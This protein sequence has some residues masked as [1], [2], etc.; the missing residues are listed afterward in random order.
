MTER[1]LIKLVLVQHEKGFRPYLFEAPAIASIGVGDR[2]TYLNNSDDIITG[3]VL[4]EATTWK[5]GDEFK[6]ALAA[7]GQSYPLPRLKSKIK[8]VEFVYEEEN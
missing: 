1:E 4:A 5:G 3:M 2:V 8:H 7:T 6:L